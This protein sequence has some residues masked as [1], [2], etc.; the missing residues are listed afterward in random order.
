LPASHFT[1]LILYICSFIGLAAVPKSLKGFKWVFPV[2]FLGSNAFLF[3]G[4]WKLH[5]FGS[6]LIFVLLTQAPWVF[7]TP[8]IILAA[9]KGLIKIQ[10]H[11]WVTWS[12]FRCLGVHYFLLF[13]AGMLPRV[14]VLHYGFMETLIGVSA[15]PVGILLS[16]GARSAQYI[17]IGWNALGFMSAWNLNYTLQSSLL[18]GAENTGQMEVISYFSQFPEI[19][20]TSFWVP[21]SLCIH[22]TLFFVLLK[23]NVA[24]NKP[25]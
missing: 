13:N 7:I 15:L 6:P 9:Q 8:Y 16:R 5:I 19:W 21:L 1:H 14:F 22:I 4:F 3:T 25:N 12:V 2:W 10:V 20:I 24:K 18:N 11:E 23:N 17:A